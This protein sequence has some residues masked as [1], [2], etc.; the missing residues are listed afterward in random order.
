MY[1]D[2]SKINDL[3]Q[4]NLNP[5][6]FDSCLSVKLKIKSSLPPTYPVPYYRN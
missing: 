4:Q 6:F 3:G 1:L 5:V 2:H